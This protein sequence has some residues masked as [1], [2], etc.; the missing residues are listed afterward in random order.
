MLQSQT[1]DNAMLL[2]N[3]R[4]AHAESNIQ[5]IDISAMK[6]TILMYKVSVLFQSY[7]IGSISL[8]GN[9]SYLKCHREA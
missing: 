8:E 7:G 5:P 2:K 4:P 9:S 6:S 1:F 3:S